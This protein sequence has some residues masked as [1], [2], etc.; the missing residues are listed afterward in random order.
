MKLR[1]LFSG[2]AVFSG[3]RSTL[4]A[5]AKFMISGKES[6]IEH[7]RR[8]ARVSNPLRT[9]E[10]HSAVFPARFTASWTLAIQGGLDSR[11]PEPRGVWTARD[12]T[13]IC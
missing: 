2:L 8:G 6:K 4:T 10:V 11:A 13:M 9:A 5:P 1:T 12:V 7:Q 3:L